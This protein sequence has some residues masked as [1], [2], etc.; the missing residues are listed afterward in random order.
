MMSFFLTKRHRICCKLLGD[1]NPLNELI[2]NA[3]LV[4]EAGSQEAVKKFANKV[5]ARGRDLMIMS[6]GALADDK[7]WKKLQFKN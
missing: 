7:L 6:V 5:L 3:E 2:E 4:I 1:V